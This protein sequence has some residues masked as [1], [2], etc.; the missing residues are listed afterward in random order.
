MSDRV[1]LNENLV[2]TVDAGARRISCA[3]CHHVISE[4]GDHLAAMAFHEG[5]N[6]EAGPQIWPD[7]AQYVD[8]PIVFRQW[9]CPSCYVAVLTQVVPKDHPTTVDEIRRVA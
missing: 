3:H 1:H 4:A 8:A 9:Y 7:P 6:T 5:P 2:L